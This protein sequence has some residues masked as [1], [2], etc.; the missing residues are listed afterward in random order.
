MRFFALFILAIVLVLPGSARAEKNHVFGDANCR[1]RV[2]CPDSSY[3]SPSDFIPAA[4]ACLTQGLG[5]NNTTGFFDNLTGLDSNNCMSS[6]SSQTSKEGG[7]TTR[8]C[9]VKQV[10]DSCVFNCKLVAN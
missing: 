9:V 1:Q 6:A 3:A 4:N 7:L 10:D 5:I 2:P 8:C